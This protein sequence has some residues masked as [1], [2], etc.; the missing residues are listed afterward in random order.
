M[1]QGA[2]QSPREVF[3]DRPFVEDQKHLLVFLGWRSRYSSQ[4]RLDVEPL[5][6]LRDWLDQG[7][8][9][10]RCIGT[11]RISIEAQD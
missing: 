6:G 11:S 5:D 4:C 2:W 9:L 10:L 1:V 8:K 7:A 3:P